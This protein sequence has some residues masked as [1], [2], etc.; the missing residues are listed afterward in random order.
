MAME[1][2]F[3]ALERAYVTAVREAGAG[4]YV[5]FEGTI[6]SRPKLDGDGSEPT[7]V[8]RRFVGVSP[9]RRC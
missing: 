9:N 5:T 8:V 2:D 6:A 3:R 7:V 1:G 4:L